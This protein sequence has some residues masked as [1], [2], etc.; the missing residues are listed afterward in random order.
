MSLILTVRRREVAVGL[1]K[2]EAGFKRGERKVIIHDW[3]EG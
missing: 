3:S 2:R 1:L